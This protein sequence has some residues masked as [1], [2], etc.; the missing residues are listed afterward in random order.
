VSLD[1]VA[2]KPG[3]AP[4]NDL[5]SRATRDWG[6]RLGLKWA[7]VT[8]VEPR[9]TARST[10]SIAASR[11]HAPAAPKRRSECDAKG[12]LLKSWGG[13][14]HLPHGAT[15]D[16]RQPLGDRARRDGKGHQVF[17]F[18]RTAGC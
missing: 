6:Q 3:G 14:V 13:H 2:R 12:T 1:Q 18:S 16:P 9:R 17:E 11:I 7:A 5:R 10:S 8:A 4:R 15:V